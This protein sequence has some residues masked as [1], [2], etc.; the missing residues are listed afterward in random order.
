MKRIKNSSEDL[1]HLRSGH[2]PNG[3]PKTIP[4]A[5]QRN[6][7]TPK[8]A[9]APNILEEFASAVEGLGLVGETRAAK[10]VYLCLST[11]LLDRP[12]S[13][14]LKATSS[15]GKSF[16]VD[17]TLKFFPREAYYDLSS[18]S[19]KAL[20]YSKEPISHRFIIIYEWSGLSSQTASYFARSLLS[21]GKIK[22]ETVESTKEGL[23]SK[24]L[25]RKGPSGLIIT[26]TAVSINAENE[27]RL[28]SVPI[29]ESQE[30]TRRIL[31]RL[32]STA[33]EDLEPNLAPWLE[34]QTWLATQQHSVVIPFATVLAR[35]I[36]PI[37]VRLRRD[38]KALLNLIRAHAILQQVQRK[39]SPDGR[40]IAELA[41]YRVV[42]ELVVDLFSEGVESTV[43]PTIRQ[44]VN[45]VTELRDETSMGD[46]IGVSTVAKH[47]KIDRSTASRRVAEAIERG[48]LKN[49]ETTKKGKQFDLI[50][51]DPLPDD[52][53]ILPTVETLRECCSVA[54]DPEDPPS[55]DDGEWEE[56]YL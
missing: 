45:A 14:A 12:V 43:S 36:P 27:T 22:H 25:E 17:R 7:A 49:Q 48:Y 24:L 33:D 34:L 54:D 35:N 6:T 2:S 4:P 38:F 28:I 5:K 41:D 18:V 32:A 23:R 52:I 51:D 16:V 39:R 11:R 47:L 29:T 8:L 56:G 46:R 1:G 13:L 30:Q 44:T 42:R 15:A 55:P 31:Q 50:L 10:L 19:D 40:I 3:K 9:L 37:S 26:T 21:E 53:Q 20:A